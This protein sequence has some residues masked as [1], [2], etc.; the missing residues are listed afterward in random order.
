[1]RLDGIENFSFEVLCW[2][3]DHRAGLKI[4]EPLM[5]EL[6]SHEYNMTKGGEGTPGRFHTEAT[7]EKLRIAQTG[8]TRSFESLKKQSAKTRGIPRGPHSQERRNA[9]S[10]AK[11]GKPQTIE[12]RMA[13]ARARIGLKPSLSALEHMRMAA[14]KRKRK[15]GRFI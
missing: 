2:G 15:N 12:A 13:A 6:F 11:K 10:V 5:I 9:I 7:K 4:A 1:M 3:D 8:K 14:T